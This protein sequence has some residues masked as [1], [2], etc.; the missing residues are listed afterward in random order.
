MD[1]MGDFFL[2]PGWLLAR[3]T[4]KYANF[5][6]VIVIFAYLNKYL[7]NYY[8]STWLSQLILPISLKLQL[9]SSLK[10]ENHQLIARSG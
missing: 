10:S 2:I 3:F 8:F 1:L 5:S 9:A 4:E 6:Q 7:V